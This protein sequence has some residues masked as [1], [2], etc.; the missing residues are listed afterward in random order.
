MEGQPKFSLHRITGIK[1][2]NIYRNG[3]CVNEIGESKVVK[4]GLE[5]N[6]VW[7]CALLGFAC[8]F[9]AKGG[10]EY[11]QPHKRK[12]GPRP[13]FGVKGNGQISS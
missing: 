4:D 5:I 10:C 13:K 11:F 3:S 9:Q 2:G 12:L 7:Q 6:T 8:Q 1:R